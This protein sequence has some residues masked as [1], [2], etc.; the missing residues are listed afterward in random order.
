MPG[1]QNPLGFVQ[2][3]ITV[4]VEPKLPTTLSLPPDSTVLQAHLLPFLASVAPGCPM[5][6]LVNVTLALP[7][8]SVRVM[9]TP[10]L[11]C[12]QL[13]SIVL[14][15]LTIHNLALLVLTA[16]RLV[17]NLLRSA[18][19]VL[20]VT[21]AEVVVSV[22]LKDLAHLDIFVLLTQVFQTPLNL[23]KWHLVLSAPVVTTVLRDL[24]VVCHVLQVHIPVDKA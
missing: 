20:L 18:L 3:A 13:G 22:H 24:V 10:T 6:Q 9:A 17:S 21:T 4:Q 19:L 23:M 15:D 12:A 14:K 16:M 5:K 8:T 2:L 11:L 1:H 7:D